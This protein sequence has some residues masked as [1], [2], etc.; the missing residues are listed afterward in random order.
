MQSQ[1]HAYNDMGKAAAASVRDPV[2]IDIRHRT[3]HTPHPPPP[4][5]VARGLKL[6]ISLQKRAP[7]MCSL[8]R[9]FPERTAAVAAT[10]MHA[11]SHTEPAP[12]AHEHMGVP[13]LTRQAETRHLHAILIK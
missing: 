10:G 11:S 6:V 1:W 12:Q 2:G 3:C 9:S 8:P 13:V 7:C 4:L 5:Q